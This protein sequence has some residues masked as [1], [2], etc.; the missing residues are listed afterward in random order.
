MFTVGSNWGRTFQSEG[1]R[2][3]KE[4][5]DQAGWAVQN[6]SDWVKLEFWVVEEVGGTRGG[7]E[8]GRRGQNMAHLGC[9][10]KVFRLHLQVAGDSSRGIGEREGGGSGSPTQMPVLGVRRPVANPLGS[11]SE[12]KGSRSES[13]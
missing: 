8:E 13:G 7:P 9:C 3:A 2:K 10:P 5:V 11:S 6:H 1:I 4:R 12:V